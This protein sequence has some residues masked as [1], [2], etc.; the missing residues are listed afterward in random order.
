MLE[1][2]VLVVGP[3]NGAGGR[4]IADAATGAVVGVAR[5]RRSRRWW[6]RLLRRAILA[7]YEA[8]DEPLVFTVCKALALGKRQQVEDAEGRS[9]GS[10]RGRVV[11][12]ANGRAVATLGNGRWRDGTG[13]EIA[14]LEVAPGGAR[15]AFAPV[16]DDP[17]VKMLLLAATLGEAP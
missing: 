4:P 11:T 15:L 5:W 7:V 8:D 2:S 13:A 16:L 12:N 1:R 9:V 14:H 17:F 10:V 6:R 3:A